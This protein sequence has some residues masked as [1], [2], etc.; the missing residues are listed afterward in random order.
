MNLPQLL[1]SGG[2]SGKAVRPLDRAKVLPSAG[3]VGSKPLELVEVES[4]QHFQSLGTL[5][6]ELQPDNSMV[7]LVPTPDD[8]AG[9]VSAVDESDGTVVLKEQVVG[10]LADSRPAGITV[11]TYCQQ[12]LMLGGSEPR[13]AGLALAPSFEMA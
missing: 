1:S 2:W 12:Q 10:Y 4:G 6:G 8:K 3:E 11:S 9:G 13:S 7:V 5:V